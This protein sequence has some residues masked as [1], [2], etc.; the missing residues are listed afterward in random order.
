MTLKLATV[1]TSMIT[2]VFIDALKQVE[3]IELAAVYSRDADKG[4]L[5]AQKHG[6]STSY[7]DWNSLCHAP[8]IDVV[9]VASPNDLHAPQSI[10]LMKA[11]KHVICEKPYVLNHQQFLEVYQVA[12][13]THQFCF[14]ALTTFH[15]PNLKHI[16][17]HLDQLG[18]IKLFTSAM[19]QYSSRFDLLKQG[20]ITNIFDVNHGGGALMDLGVYPLALCVSLFGAPERIHYQAN[21]LDSGI[22]TSG[23]LSLAYPSFQASL[24]FGKDSSGQNFTYI[25]GEQ[26]SLHVPLQPSRLTSVVLHQKA[27]ALD[28]GQVQVKN[29]MVYEIKAF[30]DIMQRNDTQ[31]Y[32]HWMSLSEKMIKV[33]DEARHQIKLSFPQDPPSNA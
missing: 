16:R 25:S 12:Q 27:E 1:G 5:F 8:D 33:L 17:N 14:D 20:Q 24:I 6:V 29:P 23:V 15:L 30:I 28:V 18:P 26:A 7:S 19:V 22:D 4:R 3:G 13:Q 32:A 2:D 11:G 21:Q 10:D 31:A 9:Y